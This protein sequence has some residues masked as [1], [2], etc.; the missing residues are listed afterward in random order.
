MFGLNKACSPHGWNFENGIG[1]AKGCWSNPE[2]DL[3]S[4]PSRAPSR[5]QAP[6]RDK[7]AQLSP[8]PSQTESRFPS[9]SLAEPQA[10][11]P[12]R[13]LSWAKPSIKL[14]QIKLSIQP[15][16]KPSP[17]HEPR[18]DESRIASR[19]EPSCDAPSLQLSRS[20]SKPSRA[21]N[22]I[23]PKPVSRAEKRALRQAEHRFGAEPNRA[24]SQAEPG[25]E[26]MTGKSSLSG[27]DQ[28][29]WRK[30]C[31]IGFPS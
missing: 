25:L 4:K 11:S 1:D 16:P 24:P 6:S 15:S 17:S 20:W 19:A 12:S 23:E 27:S 31:F 7:W 22:Q 13:A 30:L 14:M 10:E 21:T 26:P 18:C 5:S 2:T 28:L 9:Q 3:A 29:W 8:E